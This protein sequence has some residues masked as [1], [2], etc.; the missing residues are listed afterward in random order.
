MVGQMII[1]SYQTNEVA[2]PWYL[3][4]TQLKVNYT[5]QLTKSIQLTSGIN[6][7]QG[8]KAPSPLDAEVID[9]PTVFDWSASGKYKIDDQW[10]AFVQINNL[11]GINYERYLNYP[12]RGFT[13][14]V[15]VIWRF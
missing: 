10:S 15:G 8:I 14:K 2:E 5:Q 9:L 7:L 6:V 3:P 1:S 12:V 13:G 11:L 4:T